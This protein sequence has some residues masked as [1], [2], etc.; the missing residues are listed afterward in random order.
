MFGVRSNAKESIFEK[1]NQV[2]FTVTTRT[3]VLTTKWCRKWLSAGLVSERKNG[4]S[5]RLLEWMI[6]FFSMFGYC[7]ILAKIK[8]VILSLS[9]LIER[10][11]LMQFVLNIQWKADY[12]WAMCEFEISHQMF[13]MVTQKIIKFSLRNKADVR[14]ARRTLDAYT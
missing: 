10:I 4:G 11:S 9:W 8:G 5:P 13:V 12:P 14:Y 2:N 3:W 7:I 6:L 1:N